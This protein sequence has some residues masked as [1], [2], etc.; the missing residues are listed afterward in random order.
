[1][2]TGLSN[3]LNLVHCLYKHENKSSFGSKNPKLVENNADHAHVCTHLHILFLLVGLRGRRRPL[4]PRTRQGPSSARP[5]PST[6]PRPATAATTGRQ[7]NRDGHVAK[8]RI[9]Y[10]SNQT[11]SRREKFPKK[12]SLNFSL[13]WSKTSHLNL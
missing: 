4:A 5:P 10:H 9:A 6:S 8:K 3:C 13:H 2:M 12:R 11:I 1:M 7:T